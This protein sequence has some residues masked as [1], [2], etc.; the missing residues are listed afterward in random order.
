MTNI[1]INYKKTG[2][3]RNIH[4]EALHRNVFF[5][6]FDAFCSVLEYDDANTSIKRSLQKV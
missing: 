1:L 5:H 6:Q 4:F 2:N 3:T